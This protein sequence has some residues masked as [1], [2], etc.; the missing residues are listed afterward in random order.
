M[1]CIVLLFAVACANASTPGAGVHARLAN[2]PVLRGEFEQ[3]KHLQGF[4]KPLLSKGDFLLARDRGVVWNTR[5]PFASTL[6]LT[7]QRLLTRQADGS[8]HNV[9]D[10]AASPAVST[11][12]ALLMALLGGDIEVLSRQFDLQETLAVDGSWKLQLVPKQG[13]LKKIFKRIELQGD[14]YVRNVHLEEVRGDY[15]DIRFEQLRDTPTALSVEEAKQ[16]D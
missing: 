1:L 11:A 2:A 3:E 9:A 15:T 7:K 4:K 10:Q 5:S 12:N 8:T 13:A 6:V 14:K 16:F